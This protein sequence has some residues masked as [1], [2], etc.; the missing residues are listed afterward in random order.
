MATRRGGG[1]KIRTM[2]S[3]VHE[4]VQSHYSRQDLGKVILAA[5]EEEG[6]DV[7]HLT[8]ED[9]APID[10]LHFRGRV[11]TL[12]LARLV[13]LDARKG[14]LDGGSGLGGTSRCLAKEFRCHVTGIDLTEEF[15]K[16]AVML[17]DRT[18]LAQLVDYRQGDATNQTFEDDSFDVVELP[19]FG[20]PLLV[21]VCRSQRSANH[22]DLLGVA[23]SAAETSRHASD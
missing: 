18:G 8:A 19:R 22:P 12:E 5:L 1:K 14:V 16:V 15:C 4:A 17:S 13:G 21:W 10:T 11:A 23:M 3:P 20:G 7:N 2:P 9:L 6:K